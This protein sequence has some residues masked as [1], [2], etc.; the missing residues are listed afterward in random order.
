MFARVRESNQVRILYINTSR[1]WGGMEMHPLRVAEELA[2]RGNLLLFA[3]R[4]G[5]PVHAH[6]LGKRFAPLAL[7]FRW[8]VNPRSYPVLRRMV[9]AFRIDVVHMHSTRDAW[10]CLLLGGVLRKRAVLVLS[11]HLASPEKARKTDPLHRLLARRL[12]AV[13]AVSDYI[14][15]NILQTYRIES[16]KV[17]VIRYGLGPEVVGSEE[18]ARS[19]REDFGVPNHGFLVGVV[20][21]LTPDKRQDLLVQAARPVLERFPACRFLIVGGTVQRSYEEEIRRKISEADLT[22]KVLLTG[23]RN[24]ISDV[25]RALDVLVLPS[26]AEAFGLV[27][28]EAMANGRPIVGSRSGAVP[29]I[30]HHGENGLLFAPDDPE[31][32]AREVMVL[33]ASRETLDQMGKAGERMFRTRYTLENEVDSTESLYRTLLESSPPG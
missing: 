14:R 1:G 19:L 10:Q 17:R 9:R 22:G 12:D 3:V 4:K 30:V 26:R 7:P 13:V 18:R 21:Q 5:S 29:E 8:Y 20:A 16:G 2:R 32:L 24:D 6:A 23:F 11:R 15:G 27:L 25:M 28:L 31:A 33:L